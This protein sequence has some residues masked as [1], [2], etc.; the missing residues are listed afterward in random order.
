[1]SETKTSHD[2]LFKQVL[3]EFFP[4]FIELFFPQVAAYLDRDSIEFLPLELFTDLVSGDAL[5]TDL[6][7][8]ARF[9]GQAS[10]FIVIGR[11]CASTI[12]RSG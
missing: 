8:R 9:R 5:E 10:Y 2:L 11:Y 3:G 1:M 12:G 6:I 7:V 4:E